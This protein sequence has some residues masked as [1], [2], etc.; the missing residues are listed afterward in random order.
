MPSSADVPNAYPRPT[1]TSGRPRNPGSPSSPR[2]L[3][4]WRL[5]IGSGTTACS[6]KPGVT[7]MA[8]CAELKGLL[9]R[10]CCCMGSEDDHARRLIGSSRWASHDNACTE[11][12]NRAHARCQHGRLRCCSRPRTRARKDEPSGRT[13]VRAEF[14]FPWQSAWAIAVAHLCRRRKNGC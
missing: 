14:A 5:S 7:M 3:Q 6:L 1:C 4:T 13:L 9:F 10:G 8:R 2:L 11:I 12:G